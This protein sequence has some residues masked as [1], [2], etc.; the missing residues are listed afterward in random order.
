MVVFYYY[1]HSPTASSGLCSHRVIPRTIPCL[2]C[3][4]TFYVKWYSLVTNSVGCDGYHHSLP[5]V[6]DPLKLPLSSPDYIFSVIHL[7]HHLL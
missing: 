6:S 3:L 2:T 7:T 5:D 4:S 1:G